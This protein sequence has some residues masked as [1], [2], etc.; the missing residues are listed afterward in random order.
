MFK[1]LKQTPIDCEP[2][3]MLRRFRSKNASGVPFA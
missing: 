1:S 3:A 2:R